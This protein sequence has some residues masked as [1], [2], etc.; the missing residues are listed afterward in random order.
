MVSISRSPIMLQMASKAN[1]MRMNCNAL[2]R[3][4]PGVSALL[5]AYAGDKYDCRFMT[6]KPTPVLLQQ[7]SPSQPWV[8]PA[9]RVPGQTLKQY[10]TDLT[11]LA[12][13]GKLVRAIFSTNDTIKDAYNFINSFLPPW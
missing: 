4:K 2:T 5:Y 3:Q 6:T 7:S 11:E 1:A 12:E 10:S 8:N 9:N 13:Q